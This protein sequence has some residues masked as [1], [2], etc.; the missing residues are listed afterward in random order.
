M[1]L[2]VPVYAEY[3]RKSGVVHALVHT[4]IHILCTPASVV[5]R[6]Q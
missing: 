6:Q 2:T 4:V 1:R 3:V 5:S